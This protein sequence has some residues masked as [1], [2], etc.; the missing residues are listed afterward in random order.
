MADKIGFDNLVSDDLGYSARLISLEDLYRLGYERPSKCNNLSFNSNVPEWLYDSDYSYWTMNS[1][2]SGMWCI[3][4][5]QSRGNVVGN[6]YGV[7]N[8]LRPVI[9]LRRYSLEEYIEETIEISNNA[10]NGSINHDYE[11]IISEEISENEI[12]DDNNNADNIDNKDG[13]KIL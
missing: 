7:N 4:S 8:V 2:C 10:S 12:I 5:V 9:N 1:Y 3:Y 11:N 13:K 6:G